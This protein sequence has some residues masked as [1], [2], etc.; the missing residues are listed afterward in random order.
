MTRDEILAQA[1]KGGF[2]IIRVP[3]E[4]RSNFDPV[5]AAM[6]GVSADEYNICTL[7]TN[8]KL[9]GIPN[10]SIISIEQPPRPPKTEAERIAELEARIEEL[11]K[12]NTSLAYQAGE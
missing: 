9:L 3:I 11:E 10:A 7:L 5:F 12:L 4:I 1:K 8:G 2:A 6:F